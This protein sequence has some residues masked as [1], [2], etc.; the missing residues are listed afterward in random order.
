MNGDSR[1]FRAKWSIVNWILTIFVGIC[2]FVVC[3]LVLIN[4][5]GSVTGTAV[6]LIIP[7]IF[8]TALLFA[9][10]SYVINDR[11]IIIRRLGADIKLPLSQ[12]DE[13]KCITRR[14]VGMFPLRTFGVGGFAGYYGKYW[15]KKLGS[16]NAYLTNGNDLVLIR[17]KN[18]RKYLISPQRPDDFVNT[19]IN[20]QV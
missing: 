19:A 15:S 7:L 1:V 6:A 2:V 17:C 5:L 16:F 20:N 9:P 18:N 10:R 11:E 8:L 4:S 14:Q 12:I 13:V 3:P